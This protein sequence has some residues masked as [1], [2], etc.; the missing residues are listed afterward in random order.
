MNRN[1]RSGR[2]PL[3]YLAVVLV[4]AEDDA[5]DVVAA[6][7]AGRCHDLLAIL[8]PF[9]AFN[10]PDVRFNP[11]SCN[12]WMAWTISMGRSWRS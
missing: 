4:A 3:P 8:L 10:L 12:S 1:G 5:P 6:G 7:P 9:D 2:E 11:E